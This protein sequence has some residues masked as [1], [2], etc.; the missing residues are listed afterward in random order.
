MKKDYS[1][2]NHLKE[3]LSNGSEDLAWWGK[4]SGLI[5]VPTLL[6]DI[7][8]RCC[9]CKEN[10]P[11]VASLDAHQAAFRRLGTCLRR[12]DRMCLIHPNGAAY[13]ELKEDTM[14]ILSAL[15]DVNK[16][17]SPLDLL[18]PFAMPSVTNVGG[19]IKLFV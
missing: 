19:W 18:N 8:L 7:D 11:S 12:Q 13:F 1:S 16:H 14:Q 15:A 5:A 9:A 6:E 2:D 3:S 4:T 17:L 10:F